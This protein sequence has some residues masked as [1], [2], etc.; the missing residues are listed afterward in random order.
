[1]ESADLRRHAHKNTERVA[2]QDEDERLLTTNNTG[3]RQ[4]RLRLQ[5]ERRCLLINGGDRS[6]RATEKAM[7]RQGGEDRVPRPEKEN[8]EKYRG[9][10]E[11]LAVKARSPPRSRSRRGSQ[12]RIYHGIARVLMNARYRRLAANRRQEG[13]YPIAK[14]RVRSSRQPDRQIQ[15]HCGCSP[16]ALS[17][18][19]IGE[20][21][22]RH[23]NTA[24]VA[25]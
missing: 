3:Q 25:A 5:Y 21:A 11:R 13:V 1:M 12:S 18:R 22:R 19:P 10:G 8:A 2:R 24:S 9:R 4:E 16:N 15:R 7:A 20:E 17:Q 23:H 14:S 6:R